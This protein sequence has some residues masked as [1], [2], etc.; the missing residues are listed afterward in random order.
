MVYNYNNRL[1]DFDVRKTQLLTPFGIGALMDIN[2]QSVIIADSEFWDERGTKD[3]VS[4]SR[5]QKVLN[6]SGFISPPIP[7]Y[8]DYVQPYEKI[9]VKRFPKWYFSPSSR[10]LQTFSDWENEMLEQKNDKVRFRFYRQPFSIRADGHFEDLSP[11]RLFCACDHGHLQDF[12]WSEWAHQGTDISKDVA[13][14]HHLRLSSMGK[15]TS[16]GELIVRCDE[17]KTSR[18]LNGIFN[19]NSLS[20]RFEKIGVKC[21]GTHIWKNQEGVVKS[22]DRPLQV[23]LRSQSNIYYPAIRSSVNIPSDSIPL[24]QDIKSHQQFNRIQEKLKQYK[25]KEKREEFNKGRCK[26][27]M[28]DI[29]DDLSV[30]VRQI[31]KELRNYFFNY[32]DDN[33]PET[34]QSIMEYRWEEF[35]LL[36]GRKEYSEQ[37]NIDFNIK[38]IARERFS[39]YPFS[40]L[41]SGITL[42]NSLEVVSAL[43]GFTRI[44]TFDSE[45]MLLE[46]DERES[47]KDEDIKFVSLKRTDGKYIAIKNKG[48][49]IF[50]ELSRSE[51]DKW[52]LRIK[53]TMV[54]RKILSRVEHLAYKDQSQYVKPA[55]FLLHTLSHLLIKELTNSS[56]YSSSSLKERIYFSEDQGIEMTGILIYTSSSDMGGTLG[57]LVKQGLAENLFSTLTKAI[58]EARWCSFDPTC[59]DSSGQGKNSLNVAACHACTLISETSCEN[60]N[61]FLDRSVIIGTLRN[62]E[63]GYF[64]E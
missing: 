48:E 11:V 25:G 17:C 20:K 24:I 51:I 4:D 30:N 42:V 29:A 58:E 41:I 22:C 6:A 63:L 54:E 34:D 9:A 50:I 12:P 64:S 45:A 36:S 2:N 1:P 46:D 16:I 61:I 44:N 10:K 18:S 8:N 32:S 53:E 19:K 60:Q 15:S 55:Y 27:W 49:G 35:L 5:L 38:T 47:K 52:L 62:P 37:R 57:G 56:G 26:G 43:T 13:S 33:S 59:I 21:N 39:G 31:E 40:H 23:L 7:K 28:E 3:I 14:K